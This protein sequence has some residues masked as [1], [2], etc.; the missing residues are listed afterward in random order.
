[1]QIVNHV[2]DLLALQ[3]NGAA[4]PFPQFVRH[5]QIRTVFQPT[6]EVTAVLVNQRETA[7]IKRV[8]DNRVWRC[9][10]RVVKPNS[11]F[12]PKTIILGLE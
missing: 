5:H 11:R 7:V 4:A 1:M 9:F 6:Q 3:R 8:L 10:P 2:L 12:R